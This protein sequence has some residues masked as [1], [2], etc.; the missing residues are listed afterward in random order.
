MTYRSLC[1]LAFT[2]LLS[3]CS[4]KPTG[5][6]TP[7]PASIDAISKWETSGRVG[8]RTQNDALSGNFNWQ[9]DPTTFSLNIVGPFGQGATKLNKTPDGMVSLAYED[10]V[11]T[12]RNPATLLQQELGWEFPVK[13]VTYWI[14]GLADPSSYARI[15]K[16]ADSHLPAT[17]EQDG[18]LITYHNF[19]KV[20]GLSLPQKMQVSNPPF[21]VNLIINQWTIQ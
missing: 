6:I 11:V 15:T 5:P 8:I 13:Q 21:R 9:K 20:D 14:R 1:I 4:S 12:G 3:A 18:W 2:A 17:I 7:P 19:T 16:T 10:T